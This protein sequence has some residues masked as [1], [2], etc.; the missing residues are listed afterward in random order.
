MSSATLTQVGIGIVRTR[1]CLPIRSTM[2]QRLSLCWMCLSVSA[3]ASDRR[4]P[5]PSRTASMARSRSPFFV[6]ISGAF[7]SVWACRS[8]NQF[9]TRTPLALTPLMREIPAASS[10]AS[11]PLS[12]ASTASF[13]TAVILT[14]MDTEPSPRA[15][16]VRRQALSVAFVKPDRFNAHRPRLA[17]IR[18]TVRVGHATGRI[19]VSH[20]GQTL[21]FN[22]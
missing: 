20:E 1:P 3:A 22:A 11:S 2:H 16:R 5:Q 8:D 18:R 14:L 19:V 17:A 13:R 10:G 4:K 15:S 12:A 6:E 7:R 21:W 9:P